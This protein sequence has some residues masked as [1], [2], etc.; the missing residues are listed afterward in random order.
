MKK[1]HKFI[2]LFL[3]FAVI[4]IVPTNKL[5]AKTLRDYITEVEEMI[6]ELESYEEERAAAR[7]RAKEKE[8]EIAE[9]YANIEKYSLRIQEAKKEIEDTKVTIGEKEEE[10]KELLSFLQVTNGE[11]V[12]LE[13]VF[14]ATDFTDFIFR[15]AVVE[16][17][18]N[19]NDELIDEMNQL[20]TKLEEE[21][22]QLEIETKNEEK[23]IAEQNK[24]LAQINV[25]IE[26]LSDI[27]TDKEAQVKGLEEEIEYLRN[28]GCDMD[29]DITV[30]L[31]V[32]IASGF[33][34][35]VKTGVVTSEFG[36]RI[37]PLSGEGYV[38]HKGIDIALDDWNPVY[39]AASGTVGTIV[40]KA[41]CGGNIVYV[42]HL[43]DGQEYTTRYLHLSSIE[44]STGDSVTINTIV[45]YSG[46][47][48]TGTRRGGYD[49]CTTGAHL[50][51]EVN[52]GWTNIQ[53]QNPRNYIYFPSRW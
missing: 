7:A 11:N 24:L 38:Y 47:G 13:Y 21:Q 15:T 33:Y 2:I 17:L 27:Y 14:G 48:W 8:E 28:A 12:Y 29:E 49:S 20:I 3:L 37:D 9:K 18:S 42:K 50:H 1:N 23:A 36:Y 26:D 10:I 45:G 46:G 39:A 31:G 34:L 40:R 5:E 6:K 52:L 44:V 53:P 4:L 32:P 25:E 19:H 30:C 43:I 22:K 41:S 16:Q 51:F 35:P